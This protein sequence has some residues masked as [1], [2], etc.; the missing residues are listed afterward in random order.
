MPASQAL[1]KRVLILDDD[2]KLCRLIKLSLTKEG[3]D[4]VVMSN[5]LDAI[6]NIK[7][8]LYD[9][10]LLDIMMPAISGLDL[11]KEVRE[12]ST[13]P[14]IMLTALSNVKDRV[15]GFNLGADDYIVKPFFTAELVARINNALKHRLVT[16]DLTNKI[17]KFGPIEIER[18]SHIVK[19]DGERLMLSDM[20]YHILMI[21]IHSSG[22]PLDRKTIYRKLMGH[23]LDYNTRNMDVKIVH[24]RKKLGRWSSMIRTVWGIGYEIV[25][26]DLP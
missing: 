13:I 16:Q 11:L 19:L 5:G 24:L 3:F 18:A 17:T 25:V 6:P 22:I 2:K 10:L 21:L 15:N 14:V 1:K 26:V 7:N 12:F 4:C 8:N 23:E 20:E 9:I